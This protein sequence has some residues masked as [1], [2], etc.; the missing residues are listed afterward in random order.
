M[1]WFI[2]V[3]KMNMQ[4]LH[5]ETLL[6]VSNNFR[7][8]FNKK[9][10]L[11]K[12]VCQRYGIELS[13]PPGPHNPLILEFHKTNSYKAKKLQR[14]LLSLKVAGLIKDHLHSDDG[15]G[16]GKVILDVDLSDIAADECDG[17]SL[18]RPR[19]PSAESSDSGIG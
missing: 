10:S 4:M 17:D 9:S 12:T 3:I 11:M 5:D 16:P 19:H 1:I 14:D 13:G 18:K 2:P 7:K 6:D 15:S 8:V